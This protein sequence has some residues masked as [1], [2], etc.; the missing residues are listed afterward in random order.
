MTFL[1]KATRDMV[2]CKIAVSYEMG[3]FIVLCACCRYLQEQG[4]LE[5]WPTYH[6]VTYVPKQNKWRATQPDPDKK[7]KVTL[8]VYA[9]AEEAAR[10]YDRAVV[11]LMGAA[12]AAA[13]GKLN[14]PLS[15]YG[16]LLTQLQQDGYG[17]QV[18]I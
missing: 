15:N 18:S 6:G 10:A 2:L 5:A 17:A 7:K 13:S 16:D 14:F 11:R 4:N 8:G 1:K 3:R 12:A 9:T